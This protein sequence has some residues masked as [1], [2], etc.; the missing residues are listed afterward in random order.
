MDFIKENL[1]LKKENDV[2][3]KE[4]DALKQVLKLYEVSTLMDFKKIEKL[5]D[6]I[7]EL[8]NNIKELN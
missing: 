7:N 8:K 1:K 5:K 4:H 2:L 3:K 6:N